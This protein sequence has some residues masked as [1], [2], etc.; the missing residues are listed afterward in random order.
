M[1]I[2]K[3]LL[4][5]ILT[6]GTT[7]SASRAEGFYVGAGFGSSNTDNS[8]ISEELNNNLFDSKIISNSTGFRFYGGYQI[9][10]I[11]GF[12]FDYTNF[13]EFG[14]KNKD[15]GRLY[16]YNPE[17]QSISVNLGH[18][19]FNNQFRP[20]VKLG[21]GVINLNSQELFEKD[22]NLN[23]H[24]SAGVQW[25]PKELKGVGFRVEYSSDNSKSKLNSRN[26]EQEHLQSINLV[27]F[28]VQYSF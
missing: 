5:S 28:G 14:I 1:K 26:L 2:N 4:L 24:F 21:V 13:G 3:I 20:F 15:T 9:N 11:A 22:K 23:L 7:L 10:E 8:S 25:S 16:G 6:L 27:T 17:S 19:L 12:E 18:D